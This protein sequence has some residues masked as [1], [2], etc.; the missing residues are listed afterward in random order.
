MAGEIKIGTV[1]HGAGDGA[2]PI[3]AT[4]RIDGDNLSTALAAPTIACVESALDVPSTPTETGLILKLTSSTFFEDGD[5][6]TTFIE[7]LVARNWLA[8]DRQY[9]AIL[10]LHEALANAIIHGNLAIAGGN[11]ETPEEFKLQGQ[12]IVDRLGDPAFGNL[13]VTLTAQIVDNGLEISIQDCGKGFTPRPIDPDAPEPDVGILAKR[14]R[15]IG[16]IRESSDGMRH[17]DNGRRTI[18]F[19]STASNVQ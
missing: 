3:P 2:K 18:I 13:P 5:P 7:S 9:D 1:W 10:A 16:L 6:G 15:G 8:Q 17:E 14:G 19:Y 11:A 12:L 4:V